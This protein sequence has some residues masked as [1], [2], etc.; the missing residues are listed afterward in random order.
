MPSDEAE[1]VEKRAD[2]ELTATEKRDGDAGAAA[3]VR[4]RLVRG[5]VGDYVNV[6]WRRWIR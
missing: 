3:G 1:K 6:A 4:T 2:D 5:I